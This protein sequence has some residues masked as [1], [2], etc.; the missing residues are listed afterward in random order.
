MKLIQEKEH[1]KFQTVSNPE[2]I[3]Q[4]IE[5]YFIN[6]PYFIKNSKDT[7]IK[8]IQLTP[9]GNVVAETKKEIDHEI[10]MYCMFKKYVEFK[11]SVIQNLS[12]ETYLLN[13]HTVNIASEERKHK[14][15]N[16]DSNS[17]FLTK[18][19][20]SRNEINASLFNIPTSVKVHLKQYQQTLSGYADEVV[21]DVFDKSKEKF[22]LVRKSGKILFVENTSVEKSYEMPNDG[23]F[24]NYH[25]STDQDLS[26]LIREYR[27]HKIVSE[28]IVPVVYTGHDGIPVP[29]GFIQLVSKS[30]PLSI[31]KA[32]ELLKVSEEIVQKMRDSNTVMINDRQKIE[33]ISEEGLSV[34]FTHEELKKLI[35]AQSGLTFDIVFKMTQPITLY[36]EIIYIGIDREDVLAGLKIVGFSTKSA[37]SSRYS[38]L[39]NLLTG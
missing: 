14:R 35:P 23:K 6:R 5:K 39:L 26:Q 37:D 11:A 12:P 20:A 30:K 27:S 10:L 8:G 16:V 22:D 33:N 29:L 13:V 1:R 18:F 9:E 25:R 34:R 38:Q 28:M 31:E 21:V 32:D 17:V 7:F 4:L 19:R 24:L 2:K 3:R 36:T 15:F